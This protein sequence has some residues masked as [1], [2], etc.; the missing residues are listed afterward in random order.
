MRAATAGDA[1]AIAGVRAASWRAAYD[2]I[3]PAEILGR[4]TGQDAIARHVRALRDSAPPGLLIAE[5]PDRE[6][7]VVGFANLGPERASQGEPPPAPEHTEGTRAELYAIY[8]L[9]D[10]WSAG[11]G[12]ALI[13]EVLG[14]ARA[15]RYAA[16]SLWV[17]ADNPR[18][19][20]FY[21][22]AGFVLPPA[23]QVLDWLGG[24][25]EVRYELAL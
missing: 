16:I 18:A 3:I 5:L 6:A 7:V 19:R 17:L 21:E 15:A 9:P 8:V 1:E 14:Q 4:V 25:T 12:R 24:V 13:T 10:F 11:V 23:S 2:G 22:R 20:R